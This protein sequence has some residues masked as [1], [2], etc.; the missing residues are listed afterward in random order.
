MILKR[1]RNQ[2][3]GIAFIWTILAMSAI[4]GMAA[5]GVDVSMWYCRK[6]SMQGAADAAA[7]AGAFGYAHSAQTTEPG[8]TADAKAAV[9]QYLKLN[10]YA[11][12]GARIS[13]VE[14]TKADGHPN[15]YRVKLTYNQPT[16]FAAFVGMGH[17][18]LNVTATAQFVGKV[19][20]PIAYNDFG[21][22]PNASCP[23][24]KGGF[25][26]I[27]YDYELF[28]INADHGAG[29]DEGVLYQNTTNSYGDYRNEKHVGAGGFPAGYPNWPGKD[30][31][32]DVSQTYADKYNQLQV[33]LWDPD[34]WNA[35]ATAGTDSGPT[36]GKQFDE[37]RSS[38][39]HYATYEKDVPDTTVY[40]LVW[41]DD[42]GTDT[43]LGTA[44]YDGTSTWYSD[45]YG[46]NTSNF[47]DN[48]TVYGHMKSA[49]FPL[50]VPSGRDPTAMKNGSLT[51]P[52]GW[53]WISPKS[54]Y[55][56]KSGTFVVNPG[57]YVNGGRLHLRVY[58][59]DGSSENGFTIRAGPPHETDSTFGISTLDDCSWH[60]AHKDDGIQILTNGTIPLNFNQNGTAYGVALGYVPPTAAGGTFTITRFD[61]DVG[62]PGANYYYIAD[63][64][65]SQTHVYPPVISA[66]NAPKSP[67]YS[68]MQIVQ[69]AW[70]NSDEEDTDTIY[71]PPNYPGG[72]W[73]MDYHAG[74]ADTSQWHLNA[75]GGENISLVGEG[76]QLY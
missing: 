42:S 62:G 47:T 28:G 53:G 57:S 11:L 48:T 27:P 7:L 1:I 60:T 19:P 24:G 40:Q 59:T 55:G 74:S 26:S 36:S 32:I 31:T 45:G 3:R 75:T 16:Y 56:L 76:G 34:C 37:M 14:T 68:T 23:D 17:N 22:S 20:S 51:T 25:Y 4:M 52:W 63:G 69:G 64:D 61:T 49:S 50:T 67:P 72:S 13:A 43:V 39:S 18:I 58:T 38:G 66:A 71:M 70:G 10:N 6:G 21:L 46:V 54:G 9:E 73:Y 35:G 29:D 65:A 12:D 30:F 44:Q 15:W 41:T 33:E 2:E 5:W 8:K